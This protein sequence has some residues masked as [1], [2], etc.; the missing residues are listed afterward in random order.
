MPCCTLDLAGL[1][2][3]HPTAYVARLEDMEFVMGSM[4]WTVYLR[5]GPGLKDQIRDAITDGEQYVRDWIALSAHA[6]NSY[7][8]S[9]SDTAVTSDN[10]TA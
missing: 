10:I 6:V 9:D 7:S 4:F 8:N 3:Q 2:E 1:L 5:G